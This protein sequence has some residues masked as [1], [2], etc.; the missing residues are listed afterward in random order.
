[1]VRRSVRGQYKL[2]LI[3]TACAVIMIALDRDWFPEKLELA[4]GSNA[5]HNNLSC[6]G[7]FEPVATFFRLVQG[8]T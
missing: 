1:M 6:D 7:F 2:L 3:F 4:I 8:K 5:P